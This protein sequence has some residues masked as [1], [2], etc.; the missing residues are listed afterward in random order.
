MTRTSGR[1][2][3]VGTL[4]LALAACGGGDG[5]GS[6]A[7]VSTG[8]LRSFGSI[9]VNGVEWKVAGATVTLDDGQTQSL[10][11][12]DSVRTVVPQGAVVTVKGQRDAS[13]TTGTATQIEFKS[14]IEGPI[15]AKTDGGF[16][17]AG[18]NVSVDAN[19]TFFD[20]AGSAITYAALT[21]RVEVSGMPESA[22]SLHATMVRAKAGNQAEYE[23]KGYVVGLSGST[24]G[25]S[26]VSGG[27][28]YLT[29]NAPGVTLPALLANGSIA[30]VKGT[31]FTAGS[32][33][34]LT[35][36]VVELEDRLIGDDNSEAEVEGII[37][38][39]A[40]STFNV[41]GQAV[42]V[43]ASTRYVGAADPADPTADLADGIK[44]EVEGNLV[45]GTLVAEQVKFKDSVR[46]QATVSGAAGSSFTVLG[47]TVTTAAGRTRFDGLTAVANGQTVEIRG[48]P[49]IDGTTLFAQRVRLRSG[50]NDRP[51]L[52]GVVTG[53]TA[54]A[55][56][57]LGIT[58][59]TDAATQFR[60]AA[61]ATLT[62]TAFF[63]AVTVNQT[64]V[65]AKWEAGTNDTTVAAREVEL[66]GEDD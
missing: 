54:S 22:T 12:E 60:D 59:G 10:A 14:I 64:L 26:L 57:I 43:S 2:F 27:A 33:G 11:G 36:T 4:A 23:A 9:H 66:E 58:V 29:V 7:A 56:T 6:S 49:M 39:F 45:S 24:F 48:Y 15:A 25:L 52:Q 19:T 46:I 47:K 3:V 62:S 8:A 65:K 55:L 53:K 1:S 42:S 50:G 41:G 40:G 63:G 18:L 61:E 16:T 34:T 30:E 28:V 20:A 31:A 17:V 51:F 13:G 5:G 44:V 32:P 21:G 35:A 38:G 37:T